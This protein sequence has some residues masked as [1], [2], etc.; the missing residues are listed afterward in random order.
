MA[1]VVALGTSSCS[2]STC[3]AP[4]ALPRKLT[5]VTLPPGWLRL[6][7]RPSPMGSSPVANTIGTVEVTAFA[8]DAAVTLQT[9][10]ANLPADQLGYQPRQLIIATLG[11]AKF[12]RDVVSLDARN[13][14][15]S[16]IVRSMAVAAL[17]LMIRVNRVGTSTGRS[18]GFPPS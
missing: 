18:A 5:P 8:A 17:R 14:N 10:T 9:I 11:R 2:S 16:G 12:D 7:T 1:I 15:D 6:V 3:L 13:R 4:N